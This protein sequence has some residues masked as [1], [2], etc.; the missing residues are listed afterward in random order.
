MLLLSANSCSEGYSCNLLTLF[1]GKV[2]RLRRDSW[3]LLI[4]K[5]RFRCRINIDAIDAVQ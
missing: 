1:E 4:C 2:D 3:W 5:C